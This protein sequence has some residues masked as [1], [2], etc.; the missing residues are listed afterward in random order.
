MFSGETILSG[1][2]KNDHVSE[3]Q[4][5]QSGAGWYIGTLFTHCEVQDCTACGNPLLAGMQV[6]YTRETDYF[7]SEEGAENALKKF[8][9][10]GILER[11]RT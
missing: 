11:Q 5:L 1:A 7:N 4:V 3:L 8:Q 2:P 10:S 6:P 9:N